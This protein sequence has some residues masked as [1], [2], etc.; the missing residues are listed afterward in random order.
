MRVP[1]CVVCG[2]NVLTVTCHNCIKKQILACINDF[3]PEKTVLFRKH[4]GEPSTNESLTAFQCVY[5]GGV[6]KRPVCENCFN[7]MFSEWVQ[8][9][10]PGAQTLVANLFFSH[11]KNL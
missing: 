3:H 2:A 8:G 4:F 1:K 7:E 9:H 10:A 5:C 11:A 6:E